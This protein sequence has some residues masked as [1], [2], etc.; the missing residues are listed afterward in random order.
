LSEFRDAPP[1]SGLVRDFRDLTSVPGVNPDIISA[2]QEQAHLGD[3][4]IRGIEVV[5]P[6]AGKDL[7]WQAFQATMSALGGMLV[8]SAFRFEWVYGAA[9]V[10]AVFHDML[11]TVGFFSLV[12]REI[13]L[14]VIAAR[15][16]FALLAGVL[17][18]SWASIF[19]ASPW[20][21]LWDNLAGYWEATS[22]K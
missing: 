15:F 2:L 5:G 18:G 12:S 20:I 14:T 1:Q 3:F 7:Q 6:K 8:Y 10:A 19:A 13:E 16:L 4:A 21:P 22:G 9:A 17:A 11:V